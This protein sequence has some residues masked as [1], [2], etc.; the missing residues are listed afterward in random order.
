MTLL[1]IDPSV[2]FASAGIF[3]A[4]ILLLVII[5]QIAAKKLVQQG[6]VKIEVNGEKVITTGAGG[7]LLS[8]LSNE[9]LFLPSA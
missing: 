2:I 1:V 5:L 7:T 6:D 3:T 8:V 4:V 9:K